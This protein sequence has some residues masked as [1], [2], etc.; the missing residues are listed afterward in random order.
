MV[1]YRFSIAFYKKGWLK[2]VSF[3][4]NKQDCFDIEK[5]RNKRKVTGYRKCES[6]S[7]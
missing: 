2:T 6:L 7:F 5:R 3:T 1:K 4:Y